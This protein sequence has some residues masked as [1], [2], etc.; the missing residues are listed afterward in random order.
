MAI[1]QLPTGTV[2]FLFTDVE[3]STR[4]WER[5]GEVMREVLVRQAGLIAAAVAAHGG[6]R[7][8]EQGE[9]D[10]VLAVFRRAADAV[11]AAVAAQRAIDAEPWPG[12]I[13]LR[14][15]MAIHTG[16]GALRDERNYG[17]LALH[18]CARVRGL[19]HGGQI[20]VSSTTEALVRGE[21]EDRITFRDLGEHRLRDLSRPERIFQLDVG[22]L[23]S[24]FP[25]LRG[26]DAARH[27]LP[28]QLT[29][30]VGRER[31]VAEVLALLDDARLVTLAGAG[32]CG[33][34]RLGVQVAAEWV[35]TGREAWLVELAPLNDPGNLGSFVASAMGIKEEG[36]RAPVD[37][38][39]DQLSTRAAMVVLDN[40]E[41]LVDAVAEIVATLLTHAPSLTIVTTSREP[42]GVPGETVFRVPSLAVPDRAADAASAGGFDAVRLFVERARL[43]RPGFALDDETV[44]PVIEICRRLDGIPLALELAA[45]RVRMMPPAALAAALDDRFKLLGGGGRTVLGRQQTLRASVDWSYAL[46]TATEKSVLQR[47]SVFAGSFSLAAAEEVAAAVD[48]DAFEV[49]DIVAR[50]V[51]RSLVQADPDGLEAR[52]SLLET[53]RQYAFERLLDTGDTIATR[54]RHL[55]SMVALCALSAPGLD[56]P[57]LERGV[58]RMTLDDRNLAAAFD[59]AND[60]GDAE[61]MWFMCGALTF[62]W[63]STGQFSESRRRFDQCVA[64]PDVPTAEQLAARW[65]ASYLALYSGLF[66]RGITLSEECLVLARNVGDDRYAARSLHTIGTT[67]MFFD[68]DASRVV[69]QEAIELAERVD[70]PW[71]LADSMQIMSYTYLIEEDIDQALAWADRAAPIA[72]DLDNAQ[73]L[74]WDELARGQL[75]V[76]R[77]D[78]T[79]SRVRFAAA[80]RQGART[81]D[82]NIAATVLGFRAQME[83]LAGDAESWVTPVTESFDHCVRVGAGQGVVGLYF[84]QLSVLV[85]SGRAEAAAALVQAYSE[86]LVPVVPMLA[87]LLRVGEAFV[88]LANGD[89]ELARS[90][91]LDGISHPMATAVTPTGEVL[92]GYLDL[93]D[94]E[95][96]RAETRAYAALDL[97]VERGNVPDLVDAVGLLGH[98]AA[99]N[100]RIEDA[101][102]LWGAVD[103]IEARAG[104]GHGCTFIGPWLTA[105]RERVEQELGADGYLAAH[106]QGGQLSRDEVIELVTRARG[107]RGRPVSGWDSLTPTEVRV[108]E[109]AA[110]GLTNAK[111]GEQIFVAGGTVKTHLAHAYAKLGV[112]NRTELATAF[113]ARRAPA[114]S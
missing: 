86:L 68:L 37:S 13:E 6:V 34:S 24:D 17:G 88:A 100:G 101:A 3:G 65:G 79:G 72:R 95:I 111:I 57:E 78:L 21:L 49:M 76:R 15:R 97:V 90:R 44:A 9:G 22:D 40:C 77:G 36:S 71:C 42:I 80:A 45:A 110:S 30:F 98:V 102:R 85:A 1:E 14:V 41:H 56:V 12:E 75:A 16:E 27:N 62:Y 31:E 48:V 19:A 29:S 64:H 106:E 25:P 7:P 5:H 11:A 91:A 4:A 84:A 38:I 94:N 92:I 69:L 83:T 104:I 26:L 67:T 99:A 70:D 58:A 51:D 66:E 46:L 35:G 10:S 103:G 18:R 107:K 39:V 61:S 96:S 109:L 63:V 2:T 82:P 52:Y 28:V 74:A 89:R 81:G 33:K 114:G 55:H 20:L 32:G 47:L 8:T 59:W 87:P 105:G 113:T 50:L 112:A 53:I 73:L 60:V 108:V 54:D 93:G 43:A 23:A